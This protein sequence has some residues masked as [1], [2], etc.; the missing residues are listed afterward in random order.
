[1][2]RERKL[3]SVA[4]SWEPLGYLAL[5]AGTFLEGET[6]LLMAGF[7]ARRGYLYLPAVIMVAA[8]GGF[9]AD[10][11]YFFLGR[12]YGQAWIEGRPQWVVARKRLESWV[13][14]R[15]ALWML[16]MRVLY[17]M[18]IAGPVL[19]GAMKTDPFSFAVWNCAGAVLWA[20]SFSLLGYA[21]GQTL[22]LW[23][24]DLRSVERYVFIALAAG[25]GVA[26]VASRVWSRRHRAT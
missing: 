15:V 19:L 12:W 8:A 4:C 23:L 9:L 13:H 21:I 1:M 10:Q 11:A 7:A 2:A 22:E 16:A 20:V 25:G 18:R 3:D 5:F 26:W 14:G 17:G 24:E 6:V